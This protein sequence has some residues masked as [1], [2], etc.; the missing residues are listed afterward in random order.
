MM[1]KVI[2]IARNELYSLFYS[3]I[4]WTLMILFIIMT[5]GKYLDT[6]ENIMKITA[7]RGVDYLTLNI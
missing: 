3:P 2:H 7:G 5:A 1:R 6:I 4:A